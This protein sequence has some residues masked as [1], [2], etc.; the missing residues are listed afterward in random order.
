MNS[1]RLRRELSQEPLIV[2][3]KGKKSA[4]A[5]SSEVHTV[6]TYCKYT[7]ELVLSIIIPMYYLIF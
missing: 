1:E 2:Y 7:A 6:Y 4:S 5:C 3:P